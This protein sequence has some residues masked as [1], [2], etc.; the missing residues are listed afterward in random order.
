MNRGVYA[1]FTL[2]IFC[3]CGIAGISPDLDHVWDICGLQAPINLS[4]WNGRCLHTPLVFIL[5][6]IV[7]GCILATFA[8]GSI[9]F[10]QC[11]ELLDKRIARRISSMEYCAYRVDSN[12]NT[13]NNDYCADEGE[14]IR[15]GEKNIKGFI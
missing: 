14:E 13:C 7:A 6:G 10:R 12:I 2:F 4:G 1:R 9:E 11:L 3:F 8:Y 15:N 5:G